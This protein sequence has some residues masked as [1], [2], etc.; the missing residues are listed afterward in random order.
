M[1]AQE[2][3]AVLPL[4]ISEEGGSAMETAHWEW[5]L[6]VAQRALE[7]GYGELARRF[8][9]EGLAAEELSPAARRK[10]QLGLASALLSLSEGALALTVLEEMN[11]PDPDVVLR[12]ALA[13]YQA[14]DYAASALHLS[15]IEPDELIPA[16]RVWYLL[17][18][19]LLSYRDDALA[20]GTERLMQA[21]ALATS[22]VT[23]AQIEL[24]RLRAELE[25]RPASEEEVGQLRTMARSTEGQRLGFETRRMLVIVLYRLERKEEALAELDALLRLPEVIDSPRREELLLMLGLMAGP[26][27]GR[28]RLALRQL[29]SIRAEAGLQR[30]ALDLLAKAPFRGELTVE[31]DRFLQELIGQPAR[32]ALYAELL[33]LRASLMLSQNRYDLAEAVAQ[34][35]LEELPGSD[36]VPQMLRLLA[37]LN[38]QRIPP[39]YRT[40]ASY[41]DRLRAMESSAMERA[42]ILAQMGDCFFL[43]SDFSNAIEAYSSALR[44]GGGSKELNE[45][46]LF[47]EV[48]AEVRLG[49]LSAA[50]ETLDTA[51]VGNT[52]RRWE[53]EYNL[54]DALREAGRTKEAF[55]RIQHI[56]SDGTFEGLSLELQARLRWME[57]RLTLDAERI[58]EVPVLCDAI[59][60]WLENLDSISTS[61]RD[62]INSHV[63][64]LKIEALLRLG[65][66]TEGRELLGELRSS[67][68]DSGP[69]MLSYLL[70][71]RLGSGGDNVLDAQISLMNLVERFPESRYAGVSLWEAALLAEQRGVD[72][73]Y[74]E[75][76]A[77]LERL[78]KDYP[79]HSLVFFARL[80]QADLSRKL[81]DFGTA[82]DLYDRLLADYPDHPHRYRAEMSRGDCHLARGGA[83]EESLVAATVVYDRLFEDYRTPPDAAVEAGYKWATA[84]RQ[85]GLWEETR[86]A[87]FLVKVR[88]LDMPA[89]DSKLGPQGR[90]WLARSLLELGG[91]HEETGG[92]D[93][94]ERARS[95]YQVIID[96]GLPG[97]M[98]AKARLE[99][100]KP[101]EVGNIQR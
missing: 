65:M 71:S 35:L 86:A 94:I 91:L 49:R 99:L 97:G 98:M 40:A 12:M 2:S 76:M 62:A 50:M 69:A 82:L 56:S 3:E 8:F 84:L 100:L 7:Q 96:R 32:H 93:G 20:A 44:E 52:A 59:L 17:C 41:L 57:A 66:Q 87:L 29:L 36:R 10:A 21:K 90:Y 24:L 4:A 45:R 23:V 89:E 48:L 30:I 101:A 33:A 27:G 79:K 34:R 16:D 13:S 19:G 54:L 47:Q 61:Q 75:A 68:P 26:D 83:L 85:R 64:L 5:R 38:W 67:F 73:A 14:G 9:A 77:I 39:R 15:E 92:L 18:D 88:Y 55:Q 43:N 1:Q 70:E 53:A 80:K 6:D 95:I 63:I 51:A 31:F 74:R 25:H 81:N 78:I 42:R 46:C 72:S 37:T 22:T 60:G 11:A 58:A 28:G